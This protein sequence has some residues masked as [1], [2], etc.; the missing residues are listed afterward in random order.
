MRLSAT[1]STT[2][3]AHVAVDDFPNVLRNYIWRAR[4]GGAQ[5][6]GSLAVAT[7]V[8]ELCKAEQC[9]RR[10]AARQAPR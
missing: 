8:G 5:L 1:P 2:D 3:N 9:G 10:R 4:A 7:S 6:V